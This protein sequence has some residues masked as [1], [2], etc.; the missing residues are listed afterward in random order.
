MDM[1][2]K[3]DREQL[4][5]KVWSMPARDA[6]K[7]FGCSGSYLKRVCT[8]L[9]VPTPPQGYWARLRHGYKPSKAALGKLTKKE[10]DL[11]ESQ[12]ARR[13]EVEAVQRRW[14]QERTDAAAVPHPGRE[15]I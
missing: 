7:E 11:L 9:K 2:W 8:V 1:A 6:A 5:E 3:Y 15:E 13:H 4:Y 10:E 12:R 14:E